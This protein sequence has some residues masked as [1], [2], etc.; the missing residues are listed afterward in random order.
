MNFW[1]CLTMYR[2]QRNKTSLFILGETCIIYNLWGCS[3]VYKVRPLLLTDFVHKKHITM[4]AHWFHGVLYI[5]SGQCCLPVWKRSLRQSRQPRHITHEN[6]HCLRYLP[7]WQILYL[8][9]CNHYLFLLSRHSF[10]AK[11]ITGC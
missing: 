2:L 9:S 5:H 7:I 8:K 1:L 11:L 6:I 3:I 4:E 10:L